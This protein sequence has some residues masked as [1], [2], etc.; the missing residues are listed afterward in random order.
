MRI[1]IVNNLDSGLGDN[2]VFAFAREV[3]RFATEIV[4]R[5]TTKEGDPRAFL[6]D[7]DTFDAVVC[8][9][10]D[11]TCAGIAHMMAYT[12]IPI[13]PYPAGTGNLLTINLMQPT[14]DPALAKMLKNCQ[15]LDF[16]IGE[17]MFEDGKTQGFTIMAGCG[18]DAAIMRDADVSKKILGP[19]SYATAAV[20]NF[21]PTHSQ[22]D[23]TIDGR[24]IHTSGV[25]IL[26]VNF[27]RIQFDLQ[28]VHENK[29]RDG[30]FEVV[31]LHTKDAFGLIPAL[32]AAMLDRGGEFPERSDAF[33]IYSGREIH[34]TADPPLPIQFDGE[35]ANESTPFTAT[36]KQEA[37]KFIIC[38][39]AYSFYN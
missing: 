31:V 27:S 19:I 29:P 34:V 1:L 13:L 10:G 6:Y 2:P 4:I 32:F 9:G 7:A 5:S 15:T 12:E 20:A 3:S 26:L 21:A 23:L 14:D 16:D 11:G 37:S 24:E 28:V 35:L 30:L 22:I 36:V 18:Y 25:G 33:K 17:L 39:D 8:A 38:N